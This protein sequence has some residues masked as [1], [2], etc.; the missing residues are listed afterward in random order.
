[1]GRLKFVLAV[2]GHCERRTWN[3]TNTNP[4]F[5]A[6]IVPIPDPVKRASLEERNRQI[7]FARKKKR[8]HLGQDVALM[9]SQKIAKKNKQKSKKISHK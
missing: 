1:M 4:V 8:E 3:P 9:T 7:Q 6:R 5:V 2:V